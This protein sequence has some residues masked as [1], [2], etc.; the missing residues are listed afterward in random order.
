MLTEKR[1]KSTIKKN[2]ENKIEWKKEMGLMG[3]AAEFVSLS[4]GIVAWQIL[5]IV[6]LIGGIALAGY[7]LFLIIRW[8]RKQ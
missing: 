8:L 1:G 6:L 7:I 5:N 2:K 4:A 3:S